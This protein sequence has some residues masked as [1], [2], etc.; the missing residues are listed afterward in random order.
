MVF[1]QPIPQA[2][3]EQKLLIRK[4]RPVALAHETL[5]THP[6]LFIQQN[7]LFSDGLL[8]VIRFLYMPRLS[9]RNLPTP[10]RF[11]RKGRPC[12][13]STALPT[14]DALPFSSQPFL[15]FI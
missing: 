11:R 2:W 15:R 7:R 5:W 10:W 8:E 9:S 6:V 4:V 14:L 1:W 13:C 3:R 12:N